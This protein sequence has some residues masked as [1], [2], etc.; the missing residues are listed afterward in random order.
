MSHCIFMSLF[1]CSATTLA[2]HVFRDHSSYPHANLLICV[3]VSQLI[4]AVIAQ[5]VQRWAMGWTVGVLGF[6]FRR[7]L[8]IFLFTTASRTALWPTQPPIQWIP[9]AL[10]LGVKLT[11]HLHIV[12]RSRTRGAIPSLPQYVFLAWFIVKHRDNFTFTDSQLIL[13]QV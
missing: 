3:C 9:G 1:L 12:P 13:L 7:G 4:R 11:T 6:D 8:G 10:S 5:S 2:G